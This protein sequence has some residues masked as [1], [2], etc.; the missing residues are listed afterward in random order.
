MFCLG[1]IGWAFNALFYLSPLGLLPLSLGYSYYLLLRSSLGYVLFHLTVIGLKKF[2]PTLF[3]N[4]RFVA[5]LMQS[6]ILVVLGMFVQPHLPKQLESTYGLFISWSGPL[7]LLV[8][9]VQVVRLIMF[10]SKAMQIK[11]YSRPAAMKVLMLTISVVSYA[12]AGIIVYS[13]YREN[14]TVGLSSYLSI[15]CTVLV[16]LTVANVIIEEAIITDIALVSL[17][18][19]FFARVTITEA[20]STSGLESLDGEPFLTS[21]IGMTTFNNVNHL[22]SVEFL[23][24]SVIAMITLISLPFPLPL[25]D[26]SWLLSIDKSGD[27]HAN[28][29]NISIRPNVFAAGAIMMFTQLILTTTGNIEPVA[30]WW[31]LVASGVTVLYYSYKLIA[32]SQHFHTD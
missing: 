2:V 4:L 5:Y 12:L 28:D 9:A 13:L 22:L 14:L 7:F 30:V 16:G 6:V 10:A 23:I 18:L 20:L 15:I 1:L 32:S 21:I 17:F 29:P 3:L 24:S 27:E 19:A 26:D 25:D 31:R 11:M 8:Q